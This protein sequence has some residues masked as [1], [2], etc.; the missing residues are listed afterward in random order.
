MRDEIR[1][2][3]AIELYNSVVEVLE[4]A[5]K[6]AAESRSLLQRAHAQFSQITSLLNKLQGIVKIRDE[7]E[8][9]VLE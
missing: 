6:V 5:S 9:E 8:F 4:E 3:D 7:D 2:S 1:Q